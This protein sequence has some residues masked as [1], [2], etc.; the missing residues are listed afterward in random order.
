MNRLESNFMDI[1]IEIRKLIDTTIP[2]EK[3]T[4]DILLKQ[5][6]KLIVKAYYK[7]LRK[8]ETM[9]F[10]LYVVGTE[11]DSLT[12]EDLS[13]IEEYEIFETEESVK[14]EHK[15]YSIYQEDGEDI[16]GDIK[17]KYLTTKFI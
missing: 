9:N 11:Q 2:Q 3:E 16:N 4:L 7:K 15:K 6:D 14:A 10:Y 13:N 12:I 5:V 1:K 17:Y 8:T